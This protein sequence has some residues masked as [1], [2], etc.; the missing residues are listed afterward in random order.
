MLKKLGESETPLLEGVLIFRMFKASIRCLAVFEADSSRVPESSDS[1]TEPLFHVLMEI[2]LYVFQEVWTHNIAFFY[3]IAKD[4][5][6]LMELCRHIMSANSAPSPTLLAIVMKFLM[7]RLATLGNSEEMEA[8]ATIRLFRIAFN[9]VASHPQ[10]NEQILAPHLG[11]LLMDCFPL[12]AKATIPKNYFLLLRSLFRSIGGGGGR[13]EHLYK[14]VVPLLPE[15]LEC[16]NR[17]MLAC[18]DGPTKDLIVELCLTVPLRL[19]H[20][21]PHLMYLMQPLALSLR[22]PDNNLAQQGLRTL[23]LCIDNLTPDFL[24]P[25]LNAVLRD[26]MEALQ[27]HLKP[28]PGDHNNANSVIRIMGKLGGRN[29]RLLGKPPVID[30]IDDSDKPEVPL[31]FVDGRTGAIDLGPIGLLSRCIIGQHE[32]HETIVL[33]HAY[34][35]LENSVS[36]YLY[37]VRIPLLIPYFRSNVNLRKLRGGT[38][39]VSSLRLWRASSTL[40]TSKICRREQH[41]IYA[42]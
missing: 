4:R 6:A 37:Q 28:L 24:D 13:F 34:E 41:H 5:P 12:A 40:F 29:R 38:R 11:K 30:Y 8:V 3:D 39:S 10:T 23:E 1:G 27:A 20:L 15:M 9:A 31:S 19:T 35:Y 25:T 18:E 14:E 16:L 21:L 26:V 2:N 22:S 17:Q 32:K 33:L 42:C 36:Y 7:E